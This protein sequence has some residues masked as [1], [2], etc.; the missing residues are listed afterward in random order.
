MHTLDGQGNTILHI[1]A[2]RYDYSGLKEY[3]LKHKNSFTHFLNRQND[4][5]FTP[6]M[7]SIYNPIKQFSTKQSYTIN[8]K[9]LKLK[10]RQIYYIPTVI[11]LNI[12]QA[13]NRLD[14]VRL[15]LGQPGIDL[16]SKNCQGDTAL[17]LSIKSRDSKSLELLIRS[18]AS[19]LVNDGSNFLPIEIA[20]QNPELIDTK[21][22]KN[23]EHSKTQLISPYY[24]KVEIQN[25]IM[26][27]QLVSQMLTQKNKFQENGLLYSIRF[28]KIRILKILLKTVFLQNQN[29]SFL[30]ETSKNN[31]NIIHYLIKYTDTKILH[32]HLYLIKQILDNSTIDV[33]SENC[34]KETPLDM[35][36]LN[37]DFISINFLIKQGSNVRSKIVEELKELFLKDF[38]DYIPPDR[39]ITLKYW[40]CLQILNENYESSFEISFNENFKRFLVEKK[41]ILFW[42][43]K[44][45]QISTISIFKN[46]ISI[47]SHSLV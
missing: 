26:Q 30:S 35:A 40:K 10:P 11:N 47:K 25:L 22:S 24:D 41:Q 9:V 14:T 4:S 27:K 33:N 1:M 29:K 23:S 13:K 8:G 5:G 20:M 3:F 2:S 19:V 45:N 42:I 7:L 39:W 44:E 18:G 38:V 21:N 46:S 17:T 28:S 37:G 36:A 15:L 31:S 12:K 16:E 43:K 6:L 32:R 34:L